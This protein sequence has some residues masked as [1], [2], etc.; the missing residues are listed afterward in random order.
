M[1]RLIDILKAQGIALANYKVHLASAGG[2]TTP[3]DA[4]LRGEFKQWQEEQ[5][6]RNFNCDLVLG[7]VQYQGDNWVFAGVYKILGDP[8]E[9]DIGFKY[10]TELLPG[11]ED[12]LGRI[13]VKYRRQFRNSYPWGETCADNLEVAEIRQSSVSIKPFDGYNNVLLKFEELKLIVE[14]QEPSWRSALSGVN[15]V[16]LITDEKT[17][18]GYV[19]SACGKDRIWQRWCDYAQDGHGG[20]NELID[21]L[22][23]EGLP[24]ATN[25]RYSVIEV[26]DPQATED[27]VRER[28]SHWK[29]ALMTRKPF[30]YNRN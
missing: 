8:V 16:Y 3:L 2:M 24:Y 14:E 29:N 9:S 10:N 5:H 18:K 7:L 15:G 11:Q 17:G 20:N 30:G 25:F 13:I 4:F 6:N 26:I 21:L 19:G 23:A 27:Q 28:E 1:I 12:L 22:N